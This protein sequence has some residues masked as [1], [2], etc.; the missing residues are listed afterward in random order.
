M[1]GLEESGAGD[2]GGETGLEESA[3]AGVT[4]A[5]AKNGRGSTTAVGR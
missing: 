2:D 4:S 1:T 5:S 3:K